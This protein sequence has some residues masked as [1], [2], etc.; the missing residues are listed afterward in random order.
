M[1]REPA[2]RSIHIEHQRATVRK[3]VPQSEAD[4]YSKFDLLDGSH[5]WQDAVPEGYVLY[6]VK[7]LRHSK[8]LYFNYQLAKEMGLIPANHPNRLTPDLKEKILKT[9]AIQIV[10]EFDQHNLKTPI[11]KEKKTH[12]ATRYLQIQHSDKTGRTSGDGRSIWNGALRHKGVTWDVSSRGT[13]V[14]RLAPGS[15]QAGMF[16][17]TG[18]NRFGYGCGTADIDELLGSVIMSEIFHH[19]G[20]ST[21][22]VLAIVETGKGLGIGV[23]AAPNLMRPAHLLP[24]LKQKRLA[25]LRRA[26]D[27]IIDRQFQN[28]DWDVEPADRRRYSK[29][30]RNVAADFAKSAARWDVDHIF[31]WLA[32]DGD[33]VLLDGGIID[34]GSVRQFGLR[35]DQYRY[36]DVERYS[37]TLNEQRKSA[38]KIVQA[39]AQMAAY[40]ETRRYRPFEEFKNHAIVKLFD[41]EF[42]KAKLAHFLYR[43]G[44][45]PSQT[46]QI[47]SENP[48]L[49]QDLYKSSSY[50]ERM[51]T[52]RKTEKL[53]DGINRP[54]IF[55]MRSLFNRLPN[56]LLK[57]GLRPVPA[58][59]VF[60]LMCAATASTRDS[61]W[62]KSYDSKIMA[63][64]N[65]YLKVV[66]NLKGSAEHNL[67]IIN[68]RSETINRAD[69]ITGN[70][71]DVSVKEILGWR[72]KGISPE[73]IQAVLEAFIQ[74]Q[75]LLPNEDQNQEPE[76]VR[77]LPVANRLLNALTSIVH[78]Y[79]EDV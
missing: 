15:V 22:R 41:R 7:N 2:S 67:E 46:R 19:Q 68:R 17:K 35:H 24:F 40:L 34:Y 1:A 23:R 42:E 59:R 20:L 49:V 73:Q 38:R 56:L 70:S 26:F 64:Q 3:D 25:P 39:F 16:L 11:P 50:F 36:D 6:P 47:L 57:K 71:V 61:K 52:P 77:R 53:P 28:G 9:F 45:T 74:D 78:D 14:T 10:N 65:A 8:L 13:G 60:K 51:K 79:M 72:R 58:N 54:A 32:W 18:S 30:A 43:V 44:L 31:V 62:K 76:K 5:P 55:N 66:E 33:N 37:S 27:Y 63:M 48:T 4:L 29:A 21:E 75:I 12:M 69:R